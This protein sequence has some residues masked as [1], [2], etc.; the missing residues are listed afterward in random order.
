[1]KYTLVTVVCLL[2]VLHGNAVQFLRLFYKKAILIRYYV[3]NKL[4][5]IYGVLLI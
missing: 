3:D 5:V 2:C 1:M 4:I